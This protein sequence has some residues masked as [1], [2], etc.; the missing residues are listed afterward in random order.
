MIDLHCHSI[1]SDGSHSLVEL[2][3]L[4]KTV[5]VTH[6]AITDHDTTLGWEEASRLGAA[7]GIVMIPGIEISA[8][9]YARKRRAHIL[10]YFITSGHPALNTICDPLVVQRHNNSH[11][12]VEK[13]R[14]IGFKISWELV[15]TYA[16][17]TGVY[18]QHIMHALMDLGY[19]VKINGPLYKFLFARAEGDAQA[20]F[21]YLPMKYAD[22]VAAIQA[23]RAAGGVPVLAHPGDYDNFEAVPEWVESGLAGI[24]T[25][26]PNHDRKAVEQAEELAVRFNLAITAGSDFHGFYGKPRDLPGSIL[27]EASWVHALWERCGQPEEEAGHFGF[28]YC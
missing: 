7:S 13:L 11:R 5:G 8:Y 12:M 25:Y 24:E 14:E 21:A 2:I 1:Y 17:K 16:G 9:D 15:Q 6:L 22:A 27:K 26:H 19:C 28:S 18:K 20:G 23:I 10:G 3:R 4:A